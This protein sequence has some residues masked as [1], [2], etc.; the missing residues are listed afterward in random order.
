VLVETKKDTLRHCWRRSLTAVVCCAG[1]IGREQLSEAVIGYTDIER[2]KVGL[3]GAKRDT[4]VYRRDSQHVVWA[5]AGSVLLTCAALFAVLLPRVCQPCFRH[6]LI[7][8]PYLCCPNNPATARCC[9]T[10]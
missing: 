3:G 10:L 7:C 5:G 6:A 8:C 2:A 4:G 9:T 1:D